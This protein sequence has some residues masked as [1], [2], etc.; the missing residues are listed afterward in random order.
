MAAVTICSDF[1]GPQNKVSHCF[2]CFPI[3]LVQN[4][5]MCRKDNESGKCLCW[6]CLVSEVAVVLGL[7]GSPWILG[8]DLPGAGGCLGKAGL[9]E[10]LHPPTFLHFLSSFQNWRSLHVKLL[11]GY[12][13]VA[14]VTIADPR[15]SCWRTPPSESKGV[16]CPMRKEWQWT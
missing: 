1:G 10:C 4:F 5:Q 3:Y 12:S 7:L 15:K 16:P 11:P 14:P 9:A 6:W 2:H 8:V 13:D